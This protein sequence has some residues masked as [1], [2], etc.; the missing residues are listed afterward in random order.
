MNR[1]R[2]RTWGDAPISLRPLPARAHL[3]GH[4]ASTP[5]APAWGTIIVLVV[6]ILAF[7]ATVIIGLLWHIAPEL[8]VTLLGSEAGL[9]TTILAFMKPAH[10][11]NA[12]VFLAL[13]LVAASS[14]TGCGAGG[15]TIAAEAYHDTC[16][17]AHWTCTHVVDRFCPTESSPAPAPPEL[18]SGGD[19]ADAGVAVP[20]P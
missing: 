3:K 4:M 17:V 11:G 19:A 8:L 15:A 6:G 20:A 2:R 10:L 18:T 12:L 1:G 5:L 7:T 16:L 14:T 9:F 13:G